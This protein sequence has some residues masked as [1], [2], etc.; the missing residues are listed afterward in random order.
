MTYLCNNHFSVE[1]RQLLEFVLQCDF[2]ERQ[3]VITQLNSL[4]ASEIFREYTPYSW[5][6]EF[7]TEAMEPGYAGMS[8]LHRFVVD[9]KDMPWSMRYNLYLRQTRRV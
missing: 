6:M 7:R 4:K 1:E 9:H 5:Y 8:T 2:P 3:R